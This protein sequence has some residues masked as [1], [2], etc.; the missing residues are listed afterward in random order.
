[1][2]L[3]CQTRIKHGYDRGGHPLVEGSTFEELE[4]WVEH[5]RHIAQQSKVTF[6][7]ANNRARGKAVA[8]ALQLIAL[9][10][11]QPVPVPKPLIEN[12]PDLANIAAP[13]R[14]LP[15]QP[16]LPF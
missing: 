10:T 8:N 1:M 11:G 3:S 5:T 16:Q 14:T 13:S 2:Q 15:P 7:I 9:L 12:Y 6:V 4:P